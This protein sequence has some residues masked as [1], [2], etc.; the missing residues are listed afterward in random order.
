[1]EKKQHVIVMKKLFYI[2]PPQNSEV[3]TM[4]IQNYV[5]FML[6]SLPGSWH[7]EFVKLLPELV[8]EKQLDPKH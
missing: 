1:M 4:S 5:E 3:C 7:S 2:P 8:E 6:T